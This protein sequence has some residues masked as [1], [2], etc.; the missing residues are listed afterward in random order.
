[1]SFGSFLFDSSRGGVV[2]VKTNAIFWSIHSKIHWEDSVGTNLAFDLVIADEIP[3]P[4]VDVQF[5]NPIKFY[6]PF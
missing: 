2:V 6:K 1:M 4:D 5:P 3:D